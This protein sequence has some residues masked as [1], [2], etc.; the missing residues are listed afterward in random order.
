MV[1]EPKTGS[2]WQVTWFSALLGFVACETSGA[3]V[4]V[5]AAFAKSRTLKT[6]IIA[7][8]IT[9]SHTLK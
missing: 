9:G 6:I 7:D 3:P 4:G 2:L 8:F 5:S 1:L